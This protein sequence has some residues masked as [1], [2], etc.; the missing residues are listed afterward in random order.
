M[1]G[2]ANKFQLDIHAHARIATTLL[3]FV[4][5]SFFSARLKKEKKNKTFLFIQVF[6][7]FVGFRLWSHSW[8]N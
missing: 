5:L 2:G 4:S 8:R 1:Y 7:N 3:F 6:S